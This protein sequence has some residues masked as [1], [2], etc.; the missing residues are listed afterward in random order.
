MPIA[1]DAARA[2]LK[3]SPA[4]VVST[5]STG[6]GLE[7]GLEMRLLDLMHVLL[8]VSE[9]DAAVEIAQ[10]VGGTVALFI[11]LM[12]LK[13]TELGLEDTHYS[14]VHGLDA[15]GHYTS[16]HDVALAYGP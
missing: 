12:N 9:N 10:E 6:M 2:P 4:A 16:A 11:D 5:A 13:A 7:P 1:R 15:P 8:M 14:N 3:A